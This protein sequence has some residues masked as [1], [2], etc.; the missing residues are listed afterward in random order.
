MRLWLHSSGASCLVPLLLSSSPDRSHAP[1]S[2]VVL[3]LRYSLEPGSVARLSISRRTHRQHR[4]V[5][6]YVDSLSEVFI[7]GYLSKF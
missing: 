4:R 3:H 5:S 2:L 1:G 6:S 7:A